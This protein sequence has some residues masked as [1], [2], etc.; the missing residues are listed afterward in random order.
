MHDA[1]TL[2]NPGIADGQVKGGLVQGIGGALFEELSYDEH[3]QLMTG[4][5]IDYLL[6]TASDVPPIDVIHSETPSPRNTFGFKGLGEGG[7]IAPPV[8]VANAVGDALRPFGA[9]LNSTPVRAED[10]LGIIE[11]GIRASE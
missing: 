9:E 11:G 8:V 5:F 1:G 3:G 7:A 10:V 6:P 4:S 2:I